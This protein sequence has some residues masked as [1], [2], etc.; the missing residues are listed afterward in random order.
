MFAYPKFPLK[1]VQKPMN[2]VCQIFLMYN[3]VVW[4]SSNEL[5]KWIH[6]LVVTN[7]VGNDLKSIHQLMVPKLALQMND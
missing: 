6:N 3:N 4:L 5:Q 1:E 7:I 2:H